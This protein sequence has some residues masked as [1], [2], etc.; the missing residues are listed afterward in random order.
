MSTTEGILV[1]HTK[2]PAATQLLVLSELRRW[3]SAL[4]ENAL[5]EKHKNVIYKYS[6]LAFHNK[7][8]VTVGSLK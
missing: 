3:N 5:G 7:Q 2:P 8:C 4:R 1:S 6:H